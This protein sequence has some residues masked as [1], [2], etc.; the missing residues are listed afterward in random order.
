MP[1][2]QPADLWKESGRWDF[3][4]DELLRITDRHDNAFCFSPTCEELITDI[5]RKEINSYKQLPK[6]F[7]HIQ[8]KFRDERRPPLWRD[9]RARICDERCVFVPRRF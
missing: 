9:A 5:V 2:V 4:G 7:Y 3:Y 6:N 8:T 1:V